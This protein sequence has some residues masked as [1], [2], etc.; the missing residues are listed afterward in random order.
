[1]KLLKQEEHL[2]VVDMERQFYRDMVAASKDTI[3]G[4]EGPVRLGP[5][6]VVSKNIRMHYSLNF[7][8]QVHIPSDPL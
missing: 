3:A 4:M 2:R 7:A 1:M 8:Q 6:A 5:N